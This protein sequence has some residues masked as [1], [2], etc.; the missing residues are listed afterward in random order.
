LLLLGAMITLAGILTSVIWGPTR[1]W[2]G[3]AADE[4]AVDLAVR[5]AV[6]AEPERETA[7]LLAALR[8][9][10]PAVTESSDAG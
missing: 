1:A 3:M 2:I 8:R 5:A 6:S 7:R 10:V 9:L 4:D